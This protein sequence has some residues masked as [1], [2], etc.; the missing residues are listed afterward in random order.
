MERGAEDKVYLK[1]E[2][3]KGEM[4]NVNVVWKTKT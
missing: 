4:K 1:Q 2:R 3:E